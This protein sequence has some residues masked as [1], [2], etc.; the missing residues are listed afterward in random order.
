M[1]KVYSKQGCVQCNATTRK[2]LELKIGFDI[3]YV[4]QNEGAAHWLREM[5]YQQVPVV[6][7]SFDKIVTD[8]KG[9]RVVHWSG[10]RPDYLEQLAV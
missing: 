4:D 7:P 3:E 2:L 6:V 5:G 9:E 8:A 10:Y 1:V